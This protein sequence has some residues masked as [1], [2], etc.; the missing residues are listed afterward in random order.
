MVNLVNE[1]LAVG[2]IGSQIF[3]G[4]IILYFLYFQRKYAFVYNFLSAHGTKFALFI[5]LM[6]TS[7]SLFYSEYAGFTPCVLC[8]FQRIFMY[9]LVVILAISLIKKDLRI[10]DYVLSLASIG[11]MISIYHNYIYYKGISS[12]VCEIN[13]PC[14]V[15]YV[16]GFNYI[17]IPM[18]SL[19][20]FSLIITFLLIQKIKAQRDKNNH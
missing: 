13:E 14:A 10:I 5:A 16:L 4:L 11:F 3:I 8:W 19:T 20:A 1:I 2:T 15:Q 9:P 6:A 17:T 18:M 12:V 7:G